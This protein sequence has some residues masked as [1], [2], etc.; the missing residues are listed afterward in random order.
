LANFRNDSDEPLVSHKEWI[1]KFFIPVMAKNPAARV[2]MVGMAS[3][4]GDANYNMALSKR[5]IDKVA[6]VILSKGRVNIIERNPRGEIPA[7]EDGVKD[8]DRSGRYRAVL[9]RWEGL[10]GPAPVPPGPEPG[11]VFKKKVIKTQPGVWLIIGVDTFG[12]P[13]KFLSAGRIVVTLLNDKGEQWAITG[14]GVGAG[15]GA[16]FGASEAKGIIAEL[17]KLVVALGL[18]LGDVPNMAD[19]VKEFLPDLPSA[20]SGGVFRKGNIVSNFTI[21]D[22]V[23]NRAMTVISTGMGVGVVAGEGGLII[24]DRPHFIANQVEGGVPWGLYTSLGTA[25]LAAEIGGMVYAITS[26]QMKGILEKEVLELS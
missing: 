3:R 16:E 10:S 8:G 1:E 13:I 18:K 15:L 6:G 2:R 25:K 19:K 17:K 23:A 9:L 21:S 14:V 5:R 4:N 22:I 11:P 12:I 7:A 26:V 24:F 20:T